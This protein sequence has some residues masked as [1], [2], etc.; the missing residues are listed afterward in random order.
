MIEP[1]SI[2]PWTNR[3]A[4]DKEFKGIT[5]DSYSSRHYIHDCPSFERALKAQEEIQ[6][7]KWDSEEEARIVLDVIIDQL[8]RMAHEDGIMNQPVMISGQSL[9]LPTAQVD[10]FAKTI[11]TGARRV[12]EDEFVPELMTGVT[13]KFSGYYY[14]LIDCDDYVKAKLVYEVLMG[15]AAIA[16]VHAL[17]FATADVSHLTMLDF[18]F[19]RHNR[20]LIDAIQVFEE[21]QSSEVVLYINHLLEPALNATGEYSAD[22]LNTIADIIQMLSVHDDLK[23][24]RQK[25]IEALEVIVITSMTPRLAVRSHNVQHTEGIFQIMSDAKSTV[26]VPYQ[27]GDDE[28]PAVIDAAKINEIVVMPTQAYNTSEQVSDVVYEPFLIARTDGG[29]CYVPLSKITSL[30]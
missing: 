2:A 5:G 30:A 6:A 3:E 1:E 8:D 24:I 19:D 14:D 9:R 15:R 4:L 11:E 13:G 25:A 10:S 22:D 28:P 12:N 7:Q 29:V 21:T 26:P 18:A 17:Q 23:E 27:T 16:N 20:E